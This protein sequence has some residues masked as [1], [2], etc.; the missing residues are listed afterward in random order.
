MA[1]TFRPAKPTRSHYRGAADHFGLL[2]NDIVVEAA[3]GSIAPPMMAS[4]ANPLCSLVRIESG[5]GVDETG[6]AVLF[7]AFQQIHFP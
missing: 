2:P 5:G 4:V 6:G 7:D 1:S 3:T